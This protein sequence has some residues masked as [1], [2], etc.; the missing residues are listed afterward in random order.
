MPASTGKSRVARGQPAGTLTAC[1][2]HA[3]APAR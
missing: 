2:P 3:A 1:G